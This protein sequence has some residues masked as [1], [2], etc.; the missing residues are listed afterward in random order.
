MRP[1]TI[2]SLLVAPRVRFPFSGVLISCKA[3]LLAAG[4][5][6]RSD[7]AREAGHQVHPV[8]GRDRER[9]R[10]VDRRD[11]APHRVGAGSFDCRDLRERGPRC[12]M[13]GSPGFCCWRS[14]SRQLRS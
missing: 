2:A 1:A 4:C 7:R 14:S 11:P 13:S 3:F 9:D 8:D 10:H 6:V 12:A 5:G